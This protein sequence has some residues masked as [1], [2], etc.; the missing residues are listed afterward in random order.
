MEG[1]P[2]QD[3]KKPSWELFSGRTPPSLEHTSY[4][5]VVREMARLCKQRLQDDDVVLTASTVKNRDD[6]KGNDN[7]T[8]VMAGGVQRSTWLF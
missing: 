5:V 3:P 7:D 4:M 1:T 6:A 8:F 2:L